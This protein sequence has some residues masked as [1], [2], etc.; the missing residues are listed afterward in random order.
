[1]DRL[2]LPVKLT[3]LERTIA[4]LFDRPDLA[5]GAQE[6]FD[7][8]DLVAGIQVDALVRHVRERRAATAAG[9]LGFWLER[10]REWLAVPARTLDELRTLSPA[11]PRYALGAR[12]GASRAIPG[13]NV[14]LPADIAER[15]FEGR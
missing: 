11:S 3:T 12:P 7:S 4:D 15:R 2:G 6:L 8:L 5:G 13:W 9:A 10:E 14:I 1:M